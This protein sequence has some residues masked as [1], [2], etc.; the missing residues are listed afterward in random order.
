MIDGDRRIGNSVS[1]RHS[2]INDDSILHN[3]PDHHGIIPAAGGAVR[4][5]LSRPERTRGDL[6]C[7]P[8]KWYATSLPLADWPDSLPS[9]LIEHLS[10]PSGMHL[11]DEDLV[12]F[13]HHGLPGAGLFRSRPQESGRGRRMGTVGAVLGVSPPRPADSSTSCFSRRCV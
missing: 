2:A 10:L 8:V 1:T 13:T 9:A 12:T 4:H 7:L 6:L 5:P 11:R 3:H